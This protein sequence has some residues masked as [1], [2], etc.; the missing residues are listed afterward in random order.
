MRVQGNLQAHVLSCENTLRLSPVYGR[1]RPKP[2]V[3]EGILTLVE[4]Q[5]PEATLLIGVS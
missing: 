4:H 2:A 1:S 3:S 5:R